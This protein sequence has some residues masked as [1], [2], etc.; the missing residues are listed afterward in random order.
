MTYQEIIADA[1][2]TYGSEA[3]KTMVIEECSELI[4]AIAKERRK[5]VTNS[6][7]VTEI[8]DVQIMIWQLKEMY[9]RDAVDAEVESKM[10]RLAARLEAFHENEPKRGTQ[11]K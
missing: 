6:E 11:I 10:K 2:L 5:R 1:L 7:V 3:Q 4:N 9:G 8:A